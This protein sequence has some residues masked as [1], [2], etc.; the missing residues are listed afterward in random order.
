M[1]VLLV[2]QTLENG[3]ESPASVRLERKLRA[4]R[5]WSHL[6]N[7]QVTEDSSELHCANLQAPALLV[8]DGGNTTVFTDVP[9]FEQFSHNHQPS[10]PHL[11]SAC[12]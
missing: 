4:S 6:E 9:S 8:R 7:K 1:E 12:W 2:K 11:E 3:L 10:S 5:Y